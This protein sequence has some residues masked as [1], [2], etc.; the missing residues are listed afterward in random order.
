MR[1]NA[2]ISRVIFNVNIIIVSSPA[3]REKKGRNGNIDVINP[4]T[5]LLFIELQRFESKSF[6][7][8]VP[9]KYKKLQTPSPL[10]K[11]VWKYLSCCHPYS[12][13]F[14]IIL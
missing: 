5:L 12:T 10:M 13:A 4:V 8:R 14:Y 6:R 3:E 9:Y 7:S 1:T 11:D 2:F